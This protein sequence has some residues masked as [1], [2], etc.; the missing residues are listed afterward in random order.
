[1]HNHRDGAMPSIVHQIVQSRM[2]GPDRTKM[3]WASRLQFGIPMNAISSPLWPRNIL[4]PEHPRRYSN[5]N[6]T[7]RLR[8]GFN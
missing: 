6:V 3:L 1:M 4:C 2:K 5:S 8:K 7:T